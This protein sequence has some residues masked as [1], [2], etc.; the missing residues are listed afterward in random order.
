M[1][2]DISESEALMAASTRTSRGGMWL[3]RVLC[4]IWFTLALLIILTIWLSGAY[5]SRA[6][7]KL[8]LVR[9][10]TS[11]DWSIIVGMW[12]ARLLF[13]LCR[14]IIKVRHVATAGSR[15]SYYPWCDG[16][17][18][19][20]S[21]DEFSAA[22]VQA[23][24]EAAQS[25]PR[26]PRPSMILI[27]HSSFLDLFLISSLLTY[28]MIRDTHVRCVV[29]AKLT[30]LPC[31]GNGLGAFSGSFP[32]YFKAVEGGISGGESTSFSVDRERQEAD[33][34]RMREH[35]LSGGA[36][37]VCPEGTV[38]RAPPDL[39]PF[40]HGSFKLAI[41]SG[42]AIWGIVFIGCHVCWPKGVA[43][44]GYP[45]EILVSEPC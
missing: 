36:L 19:R 5:A 9:L 28:R 1:K 22:P 32:V 41:E 42:M 30:T 12:S 24:A 13:V 20:L 45:C 2:N 10:K 16:A 44:G 6:A 38:N 15:R 11:E 21:D 8:G 26:G 18:W 35:V 23:D 25:L 17:T 43:V 34:A 3:F 4:R 7:Y 39:Q 40:R 14:P 33:N 27:N 29:A 37:A 31:F